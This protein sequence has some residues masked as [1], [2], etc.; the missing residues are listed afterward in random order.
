MCITKTKVRCVIPGRNVIVKHH[1]LGYKKESCGFVKRWFSLEELPD[2]QSQGTYLSG[3]YGMDVLLRGLSAWTLKHGHFLIMG[4]FQL[5]EPVRRE[6][7]TGTQQAASDVSKAQSK[8]TL[9]VKGRKTDPEKGRAPSGNNGERRVTILTLEMLRELVKDPEF[10]IRITEDEITQRSKGDAL[11]KIIFILQ[12]SWFIMQF[13]ARH[14]QGLSFTH[15]ELTTLGLASLN[16]ITFLLWWDKPLGAQALV[17]VHMN[18][19]LTRKERAAAERV[20]C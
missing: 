4:G 2:D 6:G 7:T 3:I 17:R 20:S 18:R 9:P 1:D 12:S 8:R 5:V 15:L 11:S 13:L 10:K 19:K 16:G 14:T